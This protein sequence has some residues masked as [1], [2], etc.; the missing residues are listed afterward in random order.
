MSRTYRKQIDHYMHAWGNFYHWKEWWE[1]KTPLGYGYAWEY[2][3]NRRARDK[4]PWGKP[5]KWFKQQ[6]RRIERAKVQNAMRHE[7]YE[8]IPHFKHSDSWDWI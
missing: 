2:Q 7:D 8:N 6:K 1:I 3:V 4:K 5:P